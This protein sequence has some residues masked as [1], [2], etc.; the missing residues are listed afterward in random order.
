VENGKIRYVS[1]S[2][3]LRELKGW[4][5]IGNPVPQ[6]SVAHRLIKEPSKIQDYDEIAAD[7]WFTNGVRSYDLLAEEAMLI[8]EWDQCLSLIWLD[9][10]LRPAGRSDDYDAEDDEPLLKEL[11]GILPWP[12][13]GRK[14]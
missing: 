8:T 9:E 10:N 14:K 1:S 3:L 2:K 12:S 5:E 4:I 7:I 11:D 13:K 6:G